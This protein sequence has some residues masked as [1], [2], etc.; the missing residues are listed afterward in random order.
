MNFQLPFNSNVRVRFFEPV[1]VEGSPCHRI[2][3]LIGI[4]YSHDG[5]DSVDAISA[6]YAS[7]FHHPQHSCQE[8]AQEIKRKV[9]ESLKKEPTP[10]AS[11]E[12]SESV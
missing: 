12:D 5:F 3:D 9:D 4:S 7:Q 6:G 1:A 11:S 8:S 10:E 2:V